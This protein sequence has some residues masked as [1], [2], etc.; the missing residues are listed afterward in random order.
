MDIQDKDLSIEQKI[1]RHLVS[2]GIITKMGDAS[3][4]LKSLQH[5]QWL[6][7]AKWNNKSNSEV[8]PPPADPDSPVN[9]PVTPDTT[10][11]QPGIADDIKE[12]IKSGEIE[13]DGLECDHEALTNE[14]IQQIFDKQL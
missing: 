8:T 5:A 9:P 2:I 13:V 11:N 1:V 4:A 3:R 12:A 10:V 6:I 7:N 14:E